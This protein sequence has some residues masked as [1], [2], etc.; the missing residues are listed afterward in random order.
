MHAILAVDCGGTK[1]E[2]LLV[3]DDGDVLGW[4]RYDGFVQAAAVEHWGSGRSTAAMTHAIRSA[5][6]ETRCDS[7]AVITNFYTK[8]LWLECF[9]GLPV[10]FTAEDIP[11]SVHVRVMGD[12]KAYSA[13]DHDTAFLLADAET[14]V[15]ALAGTGAYVFGRTPDG[16][17]VL[18]DGM[19]PLLGDAGSG[20]ALGAAA[21]RAIVRSSWH[22]RHAT[23]LTEPTLAWLRRHW[24]D[25]GDFNL[26]H[27]IHTVRDRA[28]IASVARLVAEE[29]ES[30]DPIARI[31]LQDAAEALA[32]TVFD[33]VDRLGLRQ[34][35]APLIGLGS[36]AQRSPRYWAHLCDA[37][38][39]FWPAMQPVLPTLPPAVGWAMAVFVQ[40]QGSVSPAVRERLLV[41]ATAVVGEMMPT[42]AVM[43]GGYAGGTLQE[44]G[45]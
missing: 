15:A 8:S 16:R 26:V 43:A 10:P 45:T 24:Q 29:A 1:C 32:E 41:S 34:T 38:Q 7:M 4:G 39:E 31:L 17:E 23:S 22:P 42:A 2:A 19:G 11:D 18:V 12:F 5:I 28:M 25:E 37:V 36:L 14:G 21:L 33:A 6:G 20:Y 44:T 13:M 30:G 9:A 3:R 35:P 40:E 27:L